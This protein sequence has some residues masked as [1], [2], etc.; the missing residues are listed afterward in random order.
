MKSKSK[1]YINLSKQK[2]A[3]TQEILTTQKYYVQVLKLNWKLQLT[4]VTQSIALNVT[5]SHCHT[6]NKNIT[7][8]KFN[9]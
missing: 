2:V 7:E 4:C 8:H 1:N 9:L 5:K 6:K 3:F